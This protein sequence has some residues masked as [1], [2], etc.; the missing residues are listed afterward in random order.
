MGIETTWENLQAWT[1]RQPYASGIALG[2][3]DRCDVCG[4]S[5]AHPAGDGGDRCWDCKGSGHLKQA[6]KDVENRGQRRKLGPEGRWYGLHAGLGWDPPLTW[7]SSPSSPGWFKRLEYLDGT[8]R[9]EIKVFQ[10]DLPSGVMLGAF[11]VSACV[12]YPASVDPLY[13]GRALDP[14]KL[15]ENDSAFGPWCYLIDRVVLLATPVACRGMN[16]SWPVERIAG[17]SL[18]DAL[19]AAIERAT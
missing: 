12:P 15:R 19:V 9:G 17:R 14:H 1:L 6:W 18:A 13:A 2:A 3:D 10:S 4:G 7:D 16:G 11:H 5:G 8:G